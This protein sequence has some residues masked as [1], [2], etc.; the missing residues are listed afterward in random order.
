MTVRELIWMRVASAVLALSAL[1]VSRVLAWVPSDIDLARLRG[2]QANELFQR[3][4]RFVEG[5]LAHRDPICGLIPQNLKS[6]MW[7]PENSAAD[8]YPFMVLTAFLTDNAL[9]QGPLTDILHQEIRLTTRLGTLPDAF[10]FQTQSFAR[11]QMQIDPLIFGAAEYCKDGLLPL[12]EVMGRT[13]WFSR[14]WNIAADLCANAPVQTQFGPIPSTNAEVNGDVMQVVS[15]LY[16]ATGDERFLRMALAMGDAYFLEVLPQNGYLPC[17]HWNFAEHKATT[18]RLGLNDHGSE[19]L[20][21]LTE[22]YVLAAR[23][24]PEKAKAYEPALRRMIDALLDRCRRDDGLWFG[25]YDTATGKADGG[26]PDTWG[27]IL[28]GVYTCYLLTGEQRYREA[29]EK[30]M[31]AI[32]SHLDWGGAD[33]YADAI[34]S[35]IVLLNRVGVPD[36]W[37]WEEKM[38]AAMSAKQQPDGI[39]EGWH[40][41]GNVARSWLMVALAKTAGCRLQP[42]RPDLRLGAVIHGP[43]LLLSLRTDSP[44]QGNLYFDYPRH[45]YH[46]GLALNYPRLNEWPEWFTVEDGWRYSL[47]VLGGRNVPPASAIVYDGGV[48]R[49]GLPLD[50]PAG[51]EWLA[52]VALVSM[53][54]HGIPQVKIEGP[55]FVGGVGEVA[56]SLVISNLGGEPREVAVTTDWG[57][58]VPSRFTLPGNGAAT[59]TVSGT[60]SPPGAQADAPSEKTAQITA[61]LADGEGAATHRLILVSD[62]NLTDYR[63]L[64]G[65]NTYQGED[66]WW[67]N[68]GDLTLRLKVHPGKDHV[69]SLYWGCKNDTRSARLTIAG[70][71]QTVTQTGYTGFRWYDVAIPASKITGPELEVTLR[72]PDTGP[73]GF[74]GKVKM[75]VR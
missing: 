43:R 52:E 64:S 32:C 38:V 16:P 37:D 40:G 68:D 29:V 6:P 24:A 5:W 8:N 36:T 51:A 66:Y 73:I 11:P 58:V 7:T 62:P 65:S 39:I 35:G 22:V 47:R 55:D 70:E 9:L 75:T 13:E 27:Y 10:S 23:Y 21:G 12:A 56:A 30:A 50:L 42:W 14:L 69:L 2:D 60:I 18:P 49:R 1:P 72:K 4:H 28:N 34:E 67:L 17:H 63:D 45:R 53:P 59:V 74:V 3:S 31:R 19:I 61:R 15:R 26:P 20:G 33:A 41:D 57:T 48:L 25:S 44:W 71:T 54:P 46:L